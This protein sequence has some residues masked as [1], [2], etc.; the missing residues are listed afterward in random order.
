MF[1]TGF[2]HD[3]PPDRND[4]RSSDES[5]SSLEEIVSPDPFGE[6]LSANPKA[7]VWKN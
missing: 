1:G 6:K 2:R 7:N 5:K 3:L 4:V